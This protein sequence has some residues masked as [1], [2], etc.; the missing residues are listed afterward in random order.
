M[1]KE[2][3]APR[4]ENDQLYLTSP[5]LSQTR[6]IQSRQPGLGVSLPHYLIKLIT[7]RIHHHP[8]RSCG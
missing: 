8:N 2:T 3:E 1:I 6:G 4:D 5:S 7:H